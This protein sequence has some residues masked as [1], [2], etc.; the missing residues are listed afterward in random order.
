MCIQYDIKGQGSDDEPHSDTHSIGQR[1]RPEDHFW[2]LDI[3]Q[4]ETNCD[5]QIYRIFETMSDKDKTWQN[6][7]F[8]L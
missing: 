1:K 3:S 8:R 6:D 4:C 5:D 2:S 7:A